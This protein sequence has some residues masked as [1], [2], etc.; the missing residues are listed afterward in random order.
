[1]DN[2]RLH[3]NIFLGKGSTLKYTNERTLV[4]LQSQVLR[5]GVNTF[6]FG[7]VTGWEIHCFLGLYLSFLYSVQIPYTFLR[8]RNAGCTLH[9]VTPSTDGCIYKDNMISFIWVTFRLLEIKMHLLV[10]TC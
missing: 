10:Y 9:V 6:Y 4:K 3:H 5:N 8:I 2:Q 7:T 1:M